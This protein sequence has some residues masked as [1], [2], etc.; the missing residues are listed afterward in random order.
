MPHSSRIEDLVI[1]IR[2][3]SALSRR[4][5]REW[6]FLRAVSGQLWP[7]VLI[8]VTVL[9]SGAFLFQALEP[10]RRHDFVKALYYTFSL[11][12]AQPPEPF[13]DTG[14][15]RALFF[16]VPVLGLT[17]LIESIV[18]L[19]R[20]VR[21][22][23][24]SEQAWSR[25]MAE[26]MHDHV[27]L[28]GLG[29]LGYRTFTLLRRLGVPVAVVE[30]DPQNQFLDEVRKDGA[31]FIVGDAR[32]EALIEQAGVTRA[33][34]II[35]STNNDLA[36]L[37]IA[38]DA[39]RLAPGIRVVLRMFDQALADKV[40]Q[41]SNIKIAMSQSSIS[42]PAFATAAIEPSVVSTAVVNDRLIL[43]QR[44]TVRARGTLDGLTVGAVLEKFSIAIVER[45]ATSAPTSAMFPGPSTP[46]AAGDELVVQGRY[47]DLVK[48]RP[49][50][51]EANK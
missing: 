18:E 26:A 20:M 36:N 22:R 24:R 19:S 34:A 29:K 31:P 27:V 12:F 14:W 42:A 28:V 16:A 6:C 7:R 25:I 2:R 30:Q 45:R 3:E 15:L 43:M 10:E 9:L 33:R 50:A 32:R 17:V 1:D 8:L 47:E 5:W 51:A 40:A 44:W 21:D 23:T 46:L 49:E 13:P 38:L 11:I 41:I 39:R 37:E 4:V 48:L 35:V